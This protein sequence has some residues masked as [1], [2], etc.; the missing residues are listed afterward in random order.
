MN[1]QAQALAQKYFRVANGEL[2]VG[3]VPVK[4]LASEYG[5][6]AFIYDSGVIDHKLAVLRRSLP[7]R[8]SIC[9]SVKAN[10]NQTVLRHFL[11]RDCGLEIASAGEF[12]YALQAGCA[13]QRVL[14]AGPGKTEAELEFVL[15]NGIGEIHVESLVEE[16]RIAAIARRLGTRANV[17]IRVNPAGESEGGAMRMGGRPAPFGVDEESLDEILDVIF[18]ESALTFRGIHLFVGTQILEATTLVDQYRHGIAIARR[19]AKRLGHPLHTLD[20]GGGLGIPYFAHEKEFD[21]EQFHTAL[22]VLFA[23]IES[24]PAF[25]GTQFIV[26]PGRFLIGEAGIYLARVNDIK[27]SRGK[28]FLILD[29]G[30]NHHLAASGNLGQTIKRNYPVAL[31]NKLNAPAE[32]TVEVVGPLCTPLDTL[33]RNVALPRAEIGDL[34]GIFQSGAYGR[35]A[36]PLDF[37]SHPAPPEIWVAAG[38]HELICSRGGSGDASHNALTVRATHVSRGEN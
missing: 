11:S 8:F 12:R 32:E 14:F 19:V 7:S 34:F 38:R 20:F 23:G 1:D 31:L 13:P 4:M 33:A 2:V 22:A 3:E 9:F 25:T 17:A 21:L 36:S 28:K 5:T 10:P 37:L 27:V 15:A 29:G 16:R 35:T 18:A 30:M 24:D 6:P 26:E